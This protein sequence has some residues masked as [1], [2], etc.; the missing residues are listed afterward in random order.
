MK[1]ITIAITLVLL[2]VMIS[3][4]SA[5]AASVFQFSPTS[6]NTNPG[7]T[8]TLKI[9]LDPQGVKNYTSKMEIDFPANILKVNSFTFG[10]SWLPLSVSGYDLVD[11]TNGIMIKSAGYP[12]GVLNPITFGT[13]S[14]T[15][16]KE[17]NGTIIITGN[18]LV[19][20]AANQNVL[21]NVPVQTSVVVK[22][23]AVTPETPT[24][25]TEEVTPEETTL[26]PEET[27]PV[28]QVTPEDNLPTNVGI[29]GLLGSRR[30][31]FFW[32]LLALAIIGCIVYVIYRLKGKKK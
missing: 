4:A 18:S 17:G 10:G 24:I 31:D 21:S 15:T 20:N 6:V 19:L 28:A 7:K 1:K 23:V 27:T 9:T 3:T 12:G 14:F 30:A 5:S 26:Q 2:G 8:F 22:A 32:V 11:N 16:K 25:P 29:A 13:I